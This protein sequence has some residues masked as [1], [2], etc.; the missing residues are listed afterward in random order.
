MNA[1][2]RC[3]LAKFGLARFLSHLDL[4]RALGRAFR[5]AG[6]ELAYSGG[7][8]PHPQ[9]SF[10]PALAVGTESRAEYFEAVLAGEGRVADT[11]PTAINAV[12]PEGVRLLH[13]AVP[14]PSTPPLSRIDTASYLIELESPAE[15]LEAF[16]LLVER[17]SLPVV[18]RGRDLDLRPLLLDLD[19]GR[20]DR[21]ELGVL[22]VTGSAGNLRPE[23]L[24]S[25]APGNK[26]RRIMRTGLYYRENESLREPIFGGTINWKE[27]LSFL[28]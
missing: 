8:H 4:M 26:A 5:R 16:A 23:E 6:I 28:E 27:S 2:Y 1:Q 11:L 12:L 9:L 10:G 15:S 17:S 19:L 21:G 25:L 3:C 18:R 20:L 24:L 22:G 7:Y 13:A 14:G